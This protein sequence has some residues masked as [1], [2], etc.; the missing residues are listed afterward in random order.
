MQ[1]HDHLEDV[2]LIPKELGISPF[3]DKDKRVGNDF[4][5]CSTT[6]HCAD[7]HGIFFEISAVDEEGNRVPFVTGSTPGNKPSDY[8]RMARIAA[9][10]CVMLNGFDNLISIPEDIKRFLDSKRRD[11][12]ITSGDI[13]YIAQRIDEFTAGNDYNGH[14]DSICCEI[15][16]RCWPIFT[17]KGEHEDG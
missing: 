2:G 11:A 17:I 14:V 15:A 13:L 8:L 16:R 6:E 3:V 4:Y 9:E 1:L 5:F 10:C 12:D 7:G